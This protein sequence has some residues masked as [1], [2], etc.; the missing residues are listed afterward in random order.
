VFY[1]PPSGEI[2]GYAEGVPGTQECTHPS[3]AVAGFTRLGITG[4][5]TADLLTLRF[6][7]Q[8]GGWYGIIL[9]HQPP[10]S[11]LTLTRQG[12]LAFADVN[13]SQTNTIESTTLI[14]DVTGRIDVG[15]DD[16]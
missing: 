14:D 4:T 13:L 1:A 2:Y 5:I 12:N 7:Y 3:E 9:L 11:E 16:C 8:S 6:E 10:T 15:C